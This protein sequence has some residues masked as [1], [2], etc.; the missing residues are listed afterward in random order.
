MTVCPAGE[1]DAAGWEGATGEDGVGGWIMAQGGEGDTGGG[2]SGAEDDSG[3][4]TV[5]AVADIGDES[6]VGL[7][8]KW[9]PGTP[10]HDEYGRSLS[11]RVGTGLGLGGVRLL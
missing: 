1:L 10:A 2:V 3:E 9:S 7:D 4:G 8:C 5:G 11:G 6:V